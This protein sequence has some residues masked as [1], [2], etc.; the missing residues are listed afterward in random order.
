MWLAVIGSAVGA[1][2]TTTPMR[3]WYPGTG[4]VLAGPQI[5]QASPKAASPHTS[6]PSSGSKSPQVARPSPVA[7]GAAVPDI[8]TPIAGPI[9]E[10]SKEKSTQNDEIKE[11]FDVWL[12][13]DKTF[14][15]RRVLG[16]RVNG[17]VHGEVRGEDA[18]GRLMTKESYQQGVRVGTRIDYYPSGAKFADYTY[19]SAG[20]P[21]GVS[22][23]W[24]ENGKVAQEM[25]FKDGV[26]HGTMTQYFPNGRPS[27]VGTIVQGKGQGP[28]K[29]YLPDG[30][31]FGVTTLVDG[32]V[33]NN[34][35]LLELSK[36]QYEEIE[37]RA[38]WS[39]QLK[40]YWK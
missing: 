24:F 28:R 37:A 4:T 40:S 17:K 21:Q 7:A 29:H 35:V 25:H 5:S 6:R 11:P 27:V 23:R 39:P 8:V 30:R 2:L 9:A 22:R 38:S 26:S 32:E 15:R 13:E 16:I 20:L 18:E 34:S 1:L 36:A 31:L 12:D 3:T 19:D 14:P 33:V 10:D